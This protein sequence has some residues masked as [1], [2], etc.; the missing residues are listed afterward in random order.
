MRW[1]GRPTLAEGWACSAS[2]ERDHEGTGPQP[3]ASWLL[4]PVG[5]E[6]EGCLQC[7]QGHILELKTTA[8]VGE[9]FAMSTE[10]QA[11]LWERRAGQHPVALLQQD[12]DNPCE[13]CRWH[14]PLPAFVPLFYF[15]TDLISAALSNA[16]S[17]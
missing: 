8:G 7:H 3:A 10:G 6:K 5:R 2:Q 17:C 15:K 13:K 11:A 9:G 16:H 14:P 4:I 12:P 1:P